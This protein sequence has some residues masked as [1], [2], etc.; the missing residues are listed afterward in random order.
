[1]RIELDFS[2]GLLALIM[3]LATS[4]AFAEGLPSTVDPLDGL[5]GPSYGLFSVHDVPTIVAETEHDAIFLQGYLHARNRF[6]QMDTQRLLFSGRLAEL[7]GPA[8]LPTDVQLRTLGLRR[9]AEASMAVQPPEMM[10]WLE[11]YAEGVNAYLNDTSQPLPFEYTVLE[12]TRAGIE[13][14]TALD[15]VTVAKGLAFGLSFDLQDTDNTIALL[16]MQGTGAVLGFNGLALYFNDLYRVAPFDPTTSIIPGTSPGESAGTSAS[17]QESEPDPSLPSYLG[18]TTLS[19]LESYR[20][21][22]SGIPILERA[23]QSRDGKSGSNWFLAAGAIT[24]TGRAMMAH[25]PHLGLETPATFYENHLI[26][27]GSLNVT[28]TAFP[29]APGV[30]LGC[31]LD[32][33]WGST[34]NAMDVTDVY[35][36]RLVANPVPFLPPGTPTHSVFRGQQEP[37]LIIPQTFLINLLDGVPDNRVDANVPPDQGGVTFVVPRR[38]FGP[39]IDIDFSNFP[40]ISAFSVAYTGWGPTTELEA[41]RQINKSAS[42]QDFKDALQFFDFGSQ[43]FGVVDTSGN[44]AY[45]TS[46]ELPIREDLQL[47]GSPDG[48]TGPNL[49]RN[50][51]G[52][53]QHEWLPKENPQPHQSL[54]TEILPF[55]EMPQIENPT[56]GYVLNANNDPIGTTIDNM[57]FNQFRAGG[58]VLYLST[59]YAPGSRIGRMQRLFDD[60]LAGGGKVS[61]Q[62]L[63][64]FQANNQL[65]D[66]EV[67]VPYLLESFDNA[68]APGAHPTLAA[69]ASDPRVVEAMGRL[70]A[71]DFS[72]PTGIQEGYDPFDDF[73]NLPV[74]S[75]AEIDASVAATIYSMWRGQ[76]IMATIDATL[77]PRGMG[78]V[79][80]G[81]AQSMTAFRFLLDNFPFFQ[82]F[83]FSGLNFFFVPGV[84]DQTAA[85]DIIFIN[86]LVSALD[87][88]AS[89]EFEPAFGGSTD[90]N[91]Y[92]WGKLHRITLDHL[93]GPPFSVPPAGTVPDLG[94]GLS[95]ISRAGGL[96]AVDA[97]AHDVRAD[98]LD[99][100]KFDS[101]PARRLLTEMTSECPVAQE[102]I[103][104]GQSGQFGSAFQTDQLEL[105]LVND[106]HSLPVKLDDA[107]NE[108]VR[109]E[110][111]S[112]SLKPA[113]PPGPIRSAARA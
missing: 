11:A 17:T 102:V 91:D 23:L 65:L 68:T 3:A 93:I 14:W 84:T 30:V 96:G 87:L 63:Q 111:T 55:D 60:A 19:L 10:A 21:K 103:P 42:M 50:G 73:D 32:L 38:N 53:L 18:E 74:P 90:Q 80:P 105:W 110:R 54:S 44:I 77:I 67:L 36:E 71:W 47:L 31:N 101:G 109:Q 6:F 89:P 106:F 43:N 99:D 24:D 12:T 76:A 37:L 107:E 46:G 59:G 57:P 22:I 69:L 29:G 35:Q 39:I 20:D 113:R 52:V 70:A 61:L 98:G 88:L 81:D 51:E 40:V 62:Q 86:A 1:M 95:G 4:G 104:G 94:P 2:R 82:G 72:T 100:F 92:R 15:S 8:A 9:A 56:N 13:P 7:L 34:V 48:I 5:D 26:V 58:G 25:D 79:L 66:A 64:E 83:G 45:F 78:G 49:I 33:C 112:R 16:T 28:G 75:Q 41:F 27:P 108:A 85:K 97:S